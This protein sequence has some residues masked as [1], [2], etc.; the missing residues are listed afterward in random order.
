MNVEHDARNN[1][2]VVRLEDDDAELTYSMV[3]PRLIELV[4]TFVPESA[5]GHHVAD[6]LAQAAMDF[7]R[8]RGARVVPTC[9]FVRRWLAHHPDEATLV[10]PT[11]AKFLED[12]PRP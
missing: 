9:P 12:R 11:Y 10:D 7:A 6:A 2:F 4:H 5:R 3:S 1:R 8:E